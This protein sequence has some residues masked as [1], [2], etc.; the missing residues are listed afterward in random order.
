MSRKNKKENLY[1]MD[2]LLSPSN[3]RLGL[4][5]MEC[6]PAR[7]GVDR[8]MVGSSY[9]FL[10]LCLADREGVFFQQATVDNFILPYGGLVVSLQR[11]ERTV[12][13]E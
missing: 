6:H 11:E 9:P 5:V 2:C 4:G 3:L 10:R 12:G 7:G 1:E 13:L 8:M